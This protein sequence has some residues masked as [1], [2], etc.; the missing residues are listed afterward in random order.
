MKSVGIVLHFTEF[1]AKGINRI[2]LGS[3][4]C[5]THQGYDA[6]VVMLAVLLWVLSHSWNDC[7]VRVHS[8][9]V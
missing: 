5:Q 1:R 9:G 8:G 7:V 3:L 6:K 4:S 2:W